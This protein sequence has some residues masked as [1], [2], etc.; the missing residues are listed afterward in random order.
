MK[1][2]HSLVAVLF[3]VALHA[4]IPKVSKGTIVRI[5]SFPSAS[6]AK[7][8]IDVWLPPGYPEAGRYDVLYMHDGQMLFDSTITWNKQEWKVDETLA[9]L[10]AAKKIRP[11]IVVAIP[12]DG[13]RRFAE[14]FPQAAA[15]ML[16]PTA[17]DSLQK[18]VG[19]DFLAD[20]YLYFIVNE[21]KPYIESAFSVHRSKEHTFLAGSSLGGLISM[22]GL[23]SYPHIFGGAACL[24]THWP[25]SLQRITDRDN[26]IPGALARYMAANLP[27][28]GSCVLY[29]DRGDKTLDSFYASYQPL[30]DKIV[31]AKGYKARTFSSRI[32]PGA[33]HS[34]KAWA[35][36]FEEIPA[37]KDPEPLKQDVASHPGCEFTIWP[38]HG[39]Q[40]CIPGGMRTYHNVV[41]LCRRAPGRMRPAHQL[42]NFHTYCSCRHNDPLVVSEA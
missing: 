35:N 20:A 13:A 3:T 25:G 6:I 14:Y 27:P 31:R 32:F 19:G 30:I 23:C 5:D 10:M 29:M 34:E 1:A 2:L 17:K 8:N 22:Y 18:E 37:T 33:D 28:K 24:S 40:A 7:R 26:P 21:L 15:G 12:N 41:T 9:R 36:R 39:Y 4:Q 38:L 11:L 16:S 42:A